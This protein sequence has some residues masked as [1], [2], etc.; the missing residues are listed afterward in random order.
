[1]QFFEATIN[2]PPIGVIFGNQ[3]MME[4]VLSCSVI[5]RK[6]LL[7]YLTLVLITSSLNSCVCDIVDIKFVFLLGETSP[8]SFE[9]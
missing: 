2:V 8:N 9:M 3:Y 7:H 4:K 5:F 1:M 6:N